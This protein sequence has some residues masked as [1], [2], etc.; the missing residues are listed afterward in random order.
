VAASHHGDTPYS[1]NSVT[2]VPVTPYTTSVDVNPGWLDRAVPALALTFSA[3]VIKVRVLPSRRVML[4]ADQRYYDPLGLQLPSAGLHHRL[5]PA[6]F[7]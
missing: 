6:V 3:S 4:H 1:G 2:L 7:A 5:I